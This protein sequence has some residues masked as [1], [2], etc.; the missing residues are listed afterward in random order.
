MWVHRGQASLIEAEVP[1]SWERAGSSDGEQVAGALE[2]RPA[3]PV[4]THITKA[5]DE[6]GRQ[7]DT[8]AGAAWGLE[9]LGTGQGQAGLTEH[10]PRP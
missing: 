9:G 10:H 3:G 1:I 4:E 6:K 5:Q 8:P 7:E 2:C